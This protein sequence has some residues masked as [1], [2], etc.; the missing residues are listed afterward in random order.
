MEID[1][2]AE[3]PRS[4]Q[5]HVEILQIGQL[6]APPKPSDA[7]PQRP[8]RSSG[9]YTPAHVTDFISALVDDLGPIDF[10]QPV[11]D[12]ALG[13][14]GFL[15][16]AT[17]HLHDLFAAM[18]IA[19]QAKQAHETTGPDLAWVDVHGVVNVGQIKCSSGLGRAREVAQSL[20][21][22]YRAK[23]RAIVRV[24]PFSKT[25]TF[26]LPLV[27]SLL[28]AASDQVS[29][30]WRLALQLDFAQHMVA[31]AAARC[32]TS[33]RSYAYVEAAPETECSPCGVARL[34]VPVIPR[35]PGLRPAPCPVHDAYTPDGA[36]LEY[37]LAE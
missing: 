1:R 31:I 26:V 13:T 36:R 8:A 23:T 33:L 24:H 34:R 25:L 4:V 7:Q 15:R 27:D 9:L 17:Q 28:S 6:I 19:E 2:Y 37:A 18:A 20:L 22:D 16:A 30:R 11:K 32:S 10:K 35:A 5:P 21:Q 14:G 3:L 12:P 29:A